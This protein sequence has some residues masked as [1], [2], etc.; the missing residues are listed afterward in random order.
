MQ[1]FTASENEEFHLELDPG[2]FIF[3]NFNLL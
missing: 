1:V 3:S 2:Q